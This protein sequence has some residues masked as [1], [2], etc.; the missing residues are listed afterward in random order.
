M[1]LR[2]GIPLIQD[3]LNGRSGWIAGFYYIKNC[4]NALAELANDQVPEI[5][6]FVPD[7]FSETI[8]SPKHKKKVTWLNIVKI[9]NSLIENVNTHTEIEKIVN[10][11]QCDVFF[12]MMTTPKYFFEGKTVGWIPDFQDRHLQHLFSEQERDY[13]MMVTDLIIGYCDKMIC[14][15]QTVADDLKHFYADGSKKA[16]VVHFRSILSEKLFTKSPQNVL[17]KFGI[18]QKYIYLP[19]QFW[20]HK[21]HMLVFRAWQLLKVMGIDILLVCTG[22]HQD[23]RSP[24][25]YPELQKF[26]ADNKLENNIRIL[27]FISRDE[28]IQLYRGASAV[29]QPSLFEGWSTSLEDAKALGKFLLVSDIPVHR[30]QCHSS[31]AIFFD[32]SIPNALANAIKEVWN[33]LPEG[34]QPDREARALTDYQAKIIDFAE[35]LVKIFHDAKN[36]TTES[37]DKTLLLHSLVRLSRQLT[38]SELDREVRLQVINKLDAHIKESGPFIARI[39]KI[40][41]LNRQLKQIKN[42]NLELCKIVDDLKIQIELLNKAKDRVL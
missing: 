7:N 37:E 25:Y 13:R 1:K 36:V 10:S 4:L 2:V 6:V 34:F 8:L 12:P 31:T 9:S 38:L 20:I 22:S 26:I 35:C 28:Q 29:L 18:K 42:E 32:K 21:N 11:F 24:D 33:Q 14:S 41:Q 17:N 16:S 30:E 23:K 3:E 39:S 27:G 5:F 40:H 19:N 15:S